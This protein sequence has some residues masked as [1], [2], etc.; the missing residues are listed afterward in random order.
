MKRRGAVKRARKPAARRA[1]KRSVTKKRA[2]TKRPAAKRVMK[3][4]TAKRAAAKRATKTRVT[5]K[6][7]SA[8]LR[9]VKK[10]APRPAPVPP[11]FP[12]REGASAKQLLLFEMVRSRARV[13]AAIQGLTAGGAEAPVAQGR[14]SIR[15]TVLHLHAWDLEWERALEPALRGILPEWKALEG[16]P[17]D[18]YNAD[19][20][21]P[22]RSLPW[23][24]AVLRLH[25][26]WDRLLETVESM[27]EEP[28]ALWTRE[29]P[30]GETLAGLPEHDQ[31]HAEAIKRARAA[32]SPQPR[33]P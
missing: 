28:A 29:H 9:V 27:P 13:H 31:H 25:A 32:A 21:A 3:R 23:D 5:R 15:E 4:L 19:L 6:R 22:L 12:Q 2:A 33:T 30:L 24:E 17:L 14:Y 7:P 8:R 16:D 26:G 11:A 1:V 10:P 18:R 20:L